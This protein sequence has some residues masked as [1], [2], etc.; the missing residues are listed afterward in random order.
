MDFS[1]FVV[2]LLFS[3]LILRIV[4][5]SVIQNWPESR[6]SGN[7][8][9]I[10]IN[11][12]I[13]RLDTLFCDSWRFTVE[14]N[15]AGFWEKIPKR[16]LRFVEDYMTGDR[17]VSDSD[18]V[19]DD[20][21]SFASTVEIAGDGKDIWVFDIDETLLSNVPYY[22]LYG[23]GSEFYNETTW[24]EWINLAEAPALPASLRLY[25]ELRRLGFKVFLLTGRPEA[26]RNVTK[27]NLLY[28]GYRNW[29]RLIFRGD[30]EEGKRAVVYKSEKR[31]EMEAEGY[32]IHGNSGDQWSDLLGSALA[33]RSFKLPNP[34]YY[35][36]EI[37]AILILSPVTGRFREFCDS[38]RLTVETN[39][40]GLWEKIPKRCLRLMQEYMTG[41]RYMPDSDIFTE[42]SM[43]FASTVEDSMTLTTRCSLICSTTNSMDSGLHLAVAMLQVFLLS[44]RP[45]A[46]RNTTEKILLS[47]GYRNW[48]G[49][50]LRATSDEGKLAVVYK[51]EKRIEM[52][53]EGYRIHGNPG[54]QW[55]DLLG[56]S[57]AKRSFKLPNP[58]YYIT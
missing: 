50:I 4:S 6:N 52:E 17:Y 28:A 12:K 57:M 37:R 43:S 20:S 51:S 48:E 2:V 8:D 32:R 40:A 58:M 35:K 36:V 1:R 31:M 45:E 13:R 26:Q 16:C 14:T 53:A 30:S 23:F 39:N 29:E 42:D 34:V 24:D 47:V 56:F 7:L 49:L 44:G 55:S 22:Q 33:K 27:K 41:E 54:D 21:L 9:L 38:W 15:D 11:R 18:V 25:R 5:Q 19:T 46:Q 10:S 3:C